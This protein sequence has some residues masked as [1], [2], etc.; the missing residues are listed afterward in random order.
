MRAIVL[1][2]LLSLSCSPPSL[3]TDAK[4]AELLRSLQR[5]LARSVDSEKSAVLATTDEE[6]ERF[7]NES[8]QAS[9]QVEELRKQL[10]PLVTD[11]ER[12]RLDA[13]DAAWEKVAAV[14]AKLLPLA[15]AN[16]NLKAARLSSHEAAAALDAV[17]AAFSQAEA[18][19]KDPGRLREL[20]AAS[21]AALRIQA[22][23]APHIAS[24]EDAEMTAMEARMHELEQQ[25]EHAL[26]PP[27]KG[28]P[29]EVQALASAAQ[30]WA[31]YRKLT[32]K[33]ISL[34]R[35]N[36]NVY[37]YAISIHEKRDASTAC[38]AALR[39]LIE[40]VHRAPQP[41]R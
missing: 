29:A 7:A 37:S 4:K 33:I 39:A 24:A 32:E 17:L 38:D 2:S 25:V 6:S 8:R 21:V 10:R 41:S 16:T 31:E 30:P 26:T 23:H 14:D 27:P 18:A 35:E 34:S 9:A 12:Q 20:S 5:E 19:T 1:V 3:I 15:T 11:D 22:L 28:T 13:F 40:H 36:T